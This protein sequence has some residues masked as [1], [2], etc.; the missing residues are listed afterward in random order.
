MHGGPDGATAA[1]E[2]VEIAKERDDGGNGR[3]A[4][5]LRCGGLVWRGSGCS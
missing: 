4:M 2:A 5:S 3:G 1:S